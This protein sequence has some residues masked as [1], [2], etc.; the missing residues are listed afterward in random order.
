MQVL[1]MIYDY[2]VHT[3]FGSITQ[4]AKNFEYYAGTFLL[5]WSYLR[6]QKGFQMIGLGKF[7]LTATS[8]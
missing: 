8:F 5:D 2:K 4:K 3:S 6:F 1:H 7:A